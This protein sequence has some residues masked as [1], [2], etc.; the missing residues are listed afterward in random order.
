MTYYVPALVH[1]VSYTGGVQ[2]FAVQVL[3]YEHRC[4]SSTAA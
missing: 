1:F 4:L 3:A 2:L